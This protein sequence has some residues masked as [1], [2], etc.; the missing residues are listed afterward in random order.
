M[1]KRK[2]LIWANIILFILNVLLFGRILY[3]AYI[4]YQGISDTQSAYNTVGGTTYNY[5]DQS[6]GIGLSGEILS[7]SVFLSINA[8][9]SNQVATTLIGCDD[10]GCSGGANEF[11]TFE[12]IPSSAFTGTK[13]EYTLNATAAYYLNPSLY[14]FLQVQPSGGFGNSGYAFGSN[15]T[16]S[17]LGGAANCSTTQ[18]GNIKDYYFAF[19]GVIPSTDTRIIR[20][21]SPLSGSV[22]TSSVVVFNYDY[23]SNA[24]DGFNFVG[25]SVKDLTNPSERELAIKPILSEGEAEYN[26]TMTLSPGHLHL[27]RPF[28]YSSTTNQYVY[29]DW[30]SFDVVYRSASS[31]PL[32]PV[33]N[34]SSTVEY[35]N[36]FCGGFAAEDTILYDVC[37]VGGYMFVP[38]TASVQ[39]F[40]TIP[41]SLQDKFPFAYYYQVKNIISN[42]SATSTPLGTLTLSFASTSIP[43]TATIFSPTT[44]RYFIPDDVADIFK[45]LTTSTLWLAFGW[46]VWHRVRGLIKVKA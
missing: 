40:A 5:V 18:C 14:Y 8:T 20:V 25:G 2:I 30:Y 39:Q 28:L 37:Y 13:T 33:A 42:G 12:D 16:S 1:Q 17:F 36:S 38:S 27:W 11:V 6:L 15:A 35:L 3:A 22:S 29:G 45:L 9:S 34:A 23:S 4:P 46:Y 26:S 21:N 10:T 41:F 19:N 7:V 44:I 24:L 31:T 32:I 43:F